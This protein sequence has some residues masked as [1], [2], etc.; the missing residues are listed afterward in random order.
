[1]AGR[2]EGGQASVEMLAALPAL[3]LAA[4][5]GYTAREVGEIERVPLGTAK[6]RIRTAMRKLSGVAAREDD[7]EPGPGGAR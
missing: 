7:G 1:M 4:L 5:F 6:T 2:G 3:L